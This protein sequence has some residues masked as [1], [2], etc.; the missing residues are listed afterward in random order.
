MC[1]RPILNNG[2]GL[3]LEKTN[4]ELSKLE[5]IFDVL[6]DTTEVYKN[7]RELV[8]KYSVAGIKVHDTKIVAA[9]MAHGVSDLL[10]F[11]VSDF[12]RYSDISAV[13]PKDIQ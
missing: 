12:K 4:Q 6:P 13:S 2:L 5:P 9:M 8:V 1:S 10:T 7:W 11:N 3:T